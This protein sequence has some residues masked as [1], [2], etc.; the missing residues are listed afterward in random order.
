VFGTAESP[1][2][3]SVQTPDP[4]TVGIKLAKPYGPF[5]NMLANPKVGRP[6]GDPENTSRYVQI[7][8]H[9]EL[10][11]EGALNHIDRT[12][13]RYT[14]HPAFYGYVY[15]VEQRARETRVIC[16]IHARRITVDAIH[17]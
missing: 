16:R 6:V 14:R 11:T 9:A 5:R 1:L 15:P 2:V 7:R 12:T 17:A 3:E 8:G 10:D 4:K 13:R